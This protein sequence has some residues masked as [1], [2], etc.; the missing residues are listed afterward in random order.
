MKNLFLLLILVATTSLFAQNQGAIKGNI[1]DL[2]LGGEPLIFAD[3]SL[4]GTPWNTQTNFNGNFE[5]LDVAPGSYT[6]EI[7]SLGY[8][9]LKIPIEV[10]ANS[11]VQIETGIQAKSISIDEVSFLDISER[12]ESDALDK[13]EKRLP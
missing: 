10:E 1:V 13:A 5:I 7:T 12:Y 8:E 9:N 6:V 11:L 3:V 4:K 2:E